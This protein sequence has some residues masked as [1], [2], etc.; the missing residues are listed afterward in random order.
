MCASFG[1]WRGSLRPGDVS[2]CNEELGA[3]GGY[4][5]KNWIWRGKMGKEVDLHRR[6]HHRNLRWQGFEREQRA[7]ELEE[8]KWWQRA[9]RGRWLRRA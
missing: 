3:N 8:R 5:M 6:L 9:Q 4:G 1:W 2:W 7:Q